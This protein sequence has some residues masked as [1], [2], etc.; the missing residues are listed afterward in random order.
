MVGDL[1]EPRERPPLVGRVKEATPGP[2]KAGPFRVAA[3]TPVAGRR[4]ETA[5]I[6]ADRVCGPL[7]FLGPETTTVR[8]ARAN[9]VG[10]RE[11]SATA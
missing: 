11:G 10:R 4:G 9:G 6:C 1:E 3:R 5:A 8:A 7:P 2:G